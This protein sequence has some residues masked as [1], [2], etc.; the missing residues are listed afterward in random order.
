MVN[1]PEAMRSSNVFARTG[2]TTRRRAPGEACARAR[3]APAEAPPIARPAPSDVTPGPAHAWIRVFL[4]PAGTTRVGPAAE[5]DA[6]SDI[7]AA[8]AWILP[9]RA[10]PP[11][12][13]RLR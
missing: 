7:I 5:A 11:A 2:A 3:R 4:W 6:A 13:V 1:S 10:L 9:G 12:K 8:R